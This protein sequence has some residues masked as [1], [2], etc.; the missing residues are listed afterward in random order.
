MAIIENIQ[1]LINEHGSST[2]LRERL[3]LLKDQI[4]VLEKKIQI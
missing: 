4:T 2:I 3:S 1:A